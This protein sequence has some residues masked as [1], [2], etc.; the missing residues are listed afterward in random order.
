MKL[1][2]FQKKFKHHI[3]PG[4]S[5]DCIGNMRTW[6]DFDFEVFLPT[7]G[8]NLQRELCWTLEQKQALIISMLRNMNFVPFVII[9]L[10]ERDRTKKYQWQVIDGKQRLTTCFAF[11]DNEFPISVDGVNY[12]FNDLPEDMQRHI[13]R[14]D[15]RWDIHF[16][17]P[18]EPI[19]DKTKIDLFE[20]INF[21]GTPVEL[22][23]IQKLKQ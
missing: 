17:Y 23:H 7:K 3:N 1:S 6:T 9:Q 20:S 10:E 2:D 21:F 11:L 16:H 18:D 22:S 15:F 4:M 5:Y 19:T 13:F 8:L 14:F 12:Y